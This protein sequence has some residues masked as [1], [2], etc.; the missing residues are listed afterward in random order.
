LPDSRIIIA[1]TMI[2]GFDRSKAIEKS[3][4]YEISPQPTT[5]TH[6]FIHVSARCPTEAAS[7]AISAIDF[8]RAI[9]NYSLNRGIIFRIS[10]G[11]KT[12]INQIRLGPIHTLHLPNGKPIDDIFW[13]EPNF[14]QKHSPILD[15]QKDWHNI[16]KYFK[17]TQRYLRRNPQADRIKT[18]LVRYTRALDETNLTNTFLNLWSLLEFL[19]LTNNESYDITIKRTL[20]FFE[21]HVEHRQILEH[22]KTHRNNAV[23]LAKYSDDEE[24]LV[25]QIKFYVESILRYHIQQLYQFKDMEEFRMCRVDII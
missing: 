15:V 8:C 25:F 23:H 1:P 20:F 21:H 16:V 5:F 3:K 10:S 19:T 17:T 18:A 4:H 9:W 7:K 13:Y 24:T 22:L 6:V 14:F 12:P 11:K 2:T